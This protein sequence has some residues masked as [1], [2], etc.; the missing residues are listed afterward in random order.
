MP[1]D[2][3]IKNAYEILYNANHQIYITWFKYVLFTWQWWLQAALTIIPWILWAIFRKRQST[4]RLLLSGMFVFIFSYILDLIGIISGLWQYRWELLPMTPS[5]TPWD[6][7][8]IPVAV[9]L[10]LQYN[11]FNLNRYLKAIIFSA[12]AS[13]LVEPIFMHY[14]FYILIKW[15]FIYSFPITGLMYL[16]ADWLS[17]RDTVSKLN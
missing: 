11:P 10:T 13:F 5:I 2:R 4:S 14:G 15:K 7:S 9:M 12:A 3:A 17:R 16:I 6:G 8:L 1:Y